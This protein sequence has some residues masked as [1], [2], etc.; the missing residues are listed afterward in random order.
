MVEESVVRF[1]HFISI[2]C[3]SSGLATQVFLLKTHITKDTFSILL[4]ADRLCGISIILI[5]LSGLLLW[6][7]V[8]KP[9]IFYNINNT[10]H[11]KLLA[12]LLIIGLAI[13]PIRFFASFKTLPS[14]YKVPKTV[15]FLVRAQL[16]IL[17]FIP[18]LAT[19]MA[20]GF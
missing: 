19:L 6:F 10:F 2:M 14:H 3:F 1:I 4:L 5:I 17:I 12:V 11:L 9:S 15:I 13:K 7:I 16:A 8:G 20:K 18:L